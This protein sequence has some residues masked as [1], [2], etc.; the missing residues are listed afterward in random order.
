MLGAEAVVSPRAPFVREQK[1]NMQFVQM[2]IQVIFR[3]AQRASGSS[4]RCNAGAE[5]W[6]RINRED[7]S[8]G[9]CV[10]G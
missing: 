10:A 7:G 9:A 6:L 8:K 1:G 5:K 2:P 4:D 3:S